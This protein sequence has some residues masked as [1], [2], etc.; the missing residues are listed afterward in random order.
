MKKNPVSST[1]KPHP[2]SN[3]CYF[4]GVFIIYPFF[5]GGGENF[6]VLPCEGG[7]GSLECQDS[8]WGKF[9]SRFSPRLACQHYFQPDV[10]LNAFSQ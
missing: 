4:N 6:E 8:W 7:G 5:G 2:T 10:F 9:L 1:K 3:P